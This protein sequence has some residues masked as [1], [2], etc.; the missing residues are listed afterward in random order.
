MKLNK[1]IEKIRKAWNVI[2]VDTETITVYDE[3]E[4]ILYQPRFKGVNKISR[5]ITNRYKKRNFINK[6]ILNFEWEKLI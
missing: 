2:M 6:K 4:K 5:L 1:Q 3:E